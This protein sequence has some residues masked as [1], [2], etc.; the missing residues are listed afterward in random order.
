MTKR[1]QVFVAY[2]GRD[3]ALAAGIMAAVRKAN[4][5]PTPLVLTKPALCGLKHSHRFGTVKN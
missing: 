2:P 5:R 3:P 4:S 1:E